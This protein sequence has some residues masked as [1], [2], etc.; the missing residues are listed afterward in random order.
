MAKTGQFVYQQVKGAL[1]NMIGSGRYRSGDKLPSERLLAKELGCNYH[2]VRKGL[3]LLEKE[4]VIE[5][6]VGAGTFL[7]NPDL[8]SRPVV[9]P[10]FRS[11]AVKKTAARTE[12]SFL[13][14]LCPSRINEFGSELIHHLHIEAQQR[15]Y[16]LSLRTINDFGDSGR[17][18]AEEL[19]DH[20]C[21]GL[22]LPWFA[23]DVSTE[24]LW[25]LIQPLKVPVVLG[26]LFAGLEKYCYE[27]KEVFGLPTFRVIE[28][29]CRYFFELGYRNIAFFGP[30]YQDDDDF[31]RRLLGYTR[32]VS[33]N[34]L[35]PHIGL[36]GPKAQD[37]DRIVN[38]W[39]S[40]AG[41]LAVICCGDEDA[42]QFMTALH[43]H[44]LRIPQDV[45]VMGFRNIPMSAT[46]DPPLSTIQ[47]DHDYVA[48]S[49]MNHA[50][51]MMKGESAQ[52]DGRARQQLIIR[53]SCG[54]K[55][56]VGEKL[57]AIIEQSQ[58]INDKP[59]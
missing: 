19:I 7:R 22:L 44:D 9:V 2:T 51:A 36:V 57:Q 42:L 52:G 28:T 41:D 32:F 39:S 13:G 27:K 18:A 40:M 5:R 17:E 31:Q 48:R 16:K 10:S 49:I 26:K 3:A 53:E 35:T 20:G 6:R 12:K 8:S 45:A 1:E 29:A 15:G 58:E 24:E 46:S 30:D 37:V 11:G 38:R 25:N 23:T 59:A 55:L 47:F 34:A 33:R 14:V 56:R 54:G 50:E 21:D 4:Q 43:K